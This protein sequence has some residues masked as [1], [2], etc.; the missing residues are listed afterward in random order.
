MKYPHT[1]RIAIIEFISRHFCD[2]R[3]NFEYTSVQYSV[4]FRVLFSEQTDRLTDG[5]TPDIS[6]SLHPIH[7][8]V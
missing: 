2:L 4:N 6:N 1:G 3:L 7:Y 8:V 5:R